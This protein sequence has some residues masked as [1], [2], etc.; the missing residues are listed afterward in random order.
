MQQ[1]RQ[2]TAEIKAIKEI[3]IL[4]IFY[5]RDFLF[6]G[7][8]QCPV[9]PILNVFVMIV[10]SYAAHVETNFVSKLLQPEPFL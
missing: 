4:D 3:F 5:M 8:F 1:L 2:T 10:L 7:I 9:T 6:L